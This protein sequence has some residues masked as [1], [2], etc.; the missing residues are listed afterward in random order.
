M[1]IGLSGSG[2]FP[3]QGSNVYPSSGNLH[4]WYPNQKSPATEWEARIDYLY[5]EGMYSV[6]TKKAQGIWDEF[7]EILLEELPMIYLMRSR[8][9]WAVN[10]RWDLTNVYYDNIR[11]AE[12]TYIFLK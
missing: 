1:M 9:F 4:L 12:T 8:G 6:D 11:N 3:S 10:N 5:S 7:Q 2:I